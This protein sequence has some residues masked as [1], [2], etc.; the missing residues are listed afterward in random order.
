MK[1]GT[2]KAQGKLKQLITPRANCIEKGV[3]SANRV[4]ISF[5]EK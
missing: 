2:N 4:L 3:V 5:E 1:A